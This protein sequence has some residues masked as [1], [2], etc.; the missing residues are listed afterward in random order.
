MPIVYAMGWDPI[1]F[2]MIMLI[3]LEMAGSTPPFGTLLFVMKSVAPP[4]TTMGDIIR[5]GL[6]FLACDLAAMAFVIAF[7]M[8][9]LWLPSVMR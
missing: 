5:A 3:N 2:G 4:D 1:W 6:P 9:A 8:I 7:P